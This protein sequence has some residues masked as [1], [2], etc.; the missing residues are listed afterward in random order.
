MVRIRA[1]I[2]PNTRIL[3]LLEKD[4]KKPLFPSMVLYAAVDHFQ[5][6]K[7]IPSRF[8]PEKARGLKERV[9]VLQRGIA[10][11]MKDVIKNRSNIK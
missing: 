11:I 7:N 2:T 3:R 1:V 4:T 5:G 9:M 8:E 10:S 6:A